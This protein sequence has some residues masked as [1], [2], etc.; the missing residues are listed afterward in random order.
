MRM[1][2]SHP[3]TALRS[4]QTSGVGSRVCVAL[5]TKKG[6]ARIARPLSWRTGGSYLFFAAFFAAF[7]FFAICNPPFRWFVDCEFF[8]PRPGALCRLAR[9]PGCWRLSLRG[10]TPSARRVLG[11]QRLKKRGCSTR[12]PH[13]RTKNY[14]FFAAFFAAFF[15]F[16]I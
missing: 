9:R 16:A 12:A 2:V 6:D 3:L 14:R 10:L 4:P 15:F 1:T 13:T 5:Y 7:F 8:A 11:E